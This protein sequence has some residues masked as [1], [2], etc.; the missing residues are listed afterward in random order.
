MNYKTKAKGS[1][2]APPFPYSS[3]LEIA[4]LVLAGLAVASC[5]LTATIF[6]ANMESGAGWLALI[7]APLAAIVPLTIGVA[8]R[9]SARI[10]Q[11]LEQMAIRAPANEQ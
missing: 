9:R 4:W 10:E 3:T 2:V 8:L 5:L 11:F 6:F 7:S 1:R